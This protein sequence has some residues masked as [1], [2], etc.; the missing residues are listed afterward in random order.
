M[1]AH[2]YDTDLEFSDQY[3]SLLFKCLW[4]IHIIL[5]WG[6]TKL[7]IVFIVLEGLNSCFGILHHRWNAPNVLFAP[8]EVANPALGL[9]WSIAE[10]LALAR[11]ET[12]KRQECVTIVKIEV[13]CR[14]TIG[15]VEIKGGGRGRLKSPLFQRATKAREQGVYCSNSDFK[16]A[17]KETTVGGG[18]ACSACGGTPERI[19]ERIV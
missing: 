1:H 14:K 8:S 10:A 4:I 18:L 7:I 9:T 16:L 19:K 13:L 5:L 6:K 3:I 15:W 11:G 17:D 12:S 2:V